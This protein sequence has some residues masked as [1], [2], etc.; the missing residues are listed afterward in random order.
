MPAITQKSAL[1]AFDRRFYGWSAITVALI[2]LVGLP[3][4]IISKAFSEPGRSHRS[5]ISTG[6]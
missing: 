2:V 4:H 1:P 3:A 5:C 6:W